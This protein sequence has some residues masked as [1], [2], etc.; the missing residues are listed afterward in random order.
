MQQATIPSFISN[1]VTDG[2]YFILSTQQSCESDFEINCAGVETCAEG[3]SI[4]RKEF[5]YHAIEFIASGKCEV[6]MNGKTTE[7]SAGSFFVYGPETEHRIEAIGDERLVKYF[8][9]FSGTDAVQRL[10]E[11]DLTVGSKFYVGNRRWVQ[12]IFEQLLE[13][14]ELGRDDGHR[15]AQQL[16]KLLFVRLSTDRQ[17]LVSVQPYSNITF[18]RCWDY[19]SKNF[20]EVHTMQEITTACSVDGAYLTRLFRR[21]AQETPYQLLTRLKI[22]YAAELLLSETI[23]VKELGRLVGYQD[24][25]H[26]SRVFKRV[27]GLAPKSYVAFIQRGQEHTA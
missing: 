18:N 27:I 23:S 3:Y 25:Y 8:V 13:C 22:N 12:G 26:F 17:G 19:I 14:S 11:F 6:T 10:N 5:E 20:L 1:R 7:L 21:F 15:L 9:D 24:P 16:V 2:K 4:D